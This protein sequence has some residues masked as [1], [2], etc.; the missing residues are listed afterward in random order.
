[1]VKDFVIISSQRVLQ[2]NQSPKRPYHIMLFFCYFLHCQ[3]LLCGRHWGASVTE[4]LSGFSV[5]VSKN[6]L[7][8]LPLP[9]MWAERSACFEVRIS[10]LSGGGSQEECWDSNIVDEEFTACASMGRM[11]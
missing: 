5:Y 1:M 9:L 7:E 2:G 3:T 10:L 11:L 8:R 4:Y 6:S